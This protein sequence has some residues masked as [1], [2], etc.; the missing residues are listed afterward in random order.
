MNEKIERVYYVDLNNSRLRWPSDGISMVYAI[1]IVF[2]LVS[3]IVN[4]TE[5]KIER[6]GIHAHK[7]A[8]NENQ[9]Y[10]NAKHEFNKRITDDRPA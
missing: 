4:A 10:G 3:R 9:L 6:D 5:H 7:D 1:Y 8:Q 2:H